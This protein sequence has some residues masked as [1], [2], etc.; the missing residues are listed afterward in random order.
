MARSARSLEMVKQRGAEPVATDL[1][2]VNPEA[3]EGFEAVI[4][5]A[6][7]AEDWGSR[8]AFQQANVEGTRSILEAA[9]AARVR[10][11]VFVGTEAA[12]FTG[13]DLIDLD[14]ST[15]YPDRQRYLY[16]ESKA[17]AERLALSQTDLEV[18]SV[19]PRFVWGPRDTSVL[20]A[21]LRME[22]AGS[23]AWIDQGRVRTST[24]H[25]FN[26]VHALELALTEG[27]PG[28]AY[29][30]AD[31][32]TRTVR[33]FLS[34]LVR[35]GAGVEL[36]SR[37]LP[38]W[39]ARPLARIVESVWGLIW[40]DKAPPMTR[41]AIDMLSSTVTVNDSKARTD[42]GYAPVISVEDGLTQ[43]GQFCPP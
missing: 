6:A 5:C 34:A 18:I 30:V 8:D 31:D 40:P 17:E 26:V 14:E 2:T 23:F 12:F 1:S 25:V 33:E 27:R 21:L 28:E 41:F 36:S 4:H 15:P 43:L 3:L 32:G 20:P 11:F 13:R 29:F 19:R 16:S 9:Q 10:R 38:S 35:A 39:L 24:T 37:N 22:E 42:L 7:R